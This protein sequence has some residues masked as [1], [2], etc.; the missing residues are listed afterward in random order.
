MNLKTKSI[1]FTV[2]SLMA[3]MGL[4][5]GIFVGQ[6]VKKKKDMTP[7]YGTYLENPRPI[8][9]FHLTG[10]DGKLFDNKTLEG[11]WTLVFFGFTNCGSVC[12]T[13]MAELA[14]MHR[15]LE[16]K[17]AKSL[18]RIV[19][20]SIDP[21]RDTQEKLASYVTSFNKNF[22]GALGNEESIESMTQE[23]G[24]AYTKVILKKEDS[25]TY[26]MQHSGALVLFNP[27]GELNAF[28]TTPHHADLLAKD[29]LLLV[30]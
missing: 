21:E 7:F 8:N 17:N 30:S 27:K 18:P 29:Y 24:I 16:E 11:T 5:A 13:T 23:M 2:I 14:K 25:K 28:F 15:I 22:Y 6:H 4:V 26:D 10:I 19:M 9:Q 3:F 20:I 12:P 1:T